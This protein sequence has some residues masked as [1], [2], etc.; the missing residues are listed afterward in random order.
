MENTQEKMKIRIALL[1]YQTKLVNALLK[2][3]IEGENIDAKIG[4]LDMKILI[5]KLINEIN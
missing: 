5:I 2:T 4:A 3:Q 1:D